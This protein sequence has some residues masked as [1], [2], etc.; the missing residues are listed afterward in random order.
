MSKKPA[1]IERFSWIIMLAIAANIFSGLFVLQNNTSVDQSGVTISADGADGLLISIIPVIFQSILLY[2]IACKRSVIA[3]WAFVI[4]API[5]LL[6]TASV[7]LLLFAIGQFA[8]GAIIATLVIMMI[9]AIFLLF[10]TSARA[11]FAS[12]A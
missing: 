8:L 12:K 2:L 11:W 9:Y 10:S 4:L 1:E 3:K 5:G 6:K 7:A